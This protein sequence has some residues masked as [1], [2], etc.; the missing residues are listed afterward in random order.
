MKKSISEKVITLFLVS[1]LLSGCAGPTVAPTF[2]ELNVT[3]KFKKTVAIIDIDDRGSQIKGISPIVISELE[4][5]MFGYCNLVER[6]K[7]SAI[8][9][10]RQFTADQNAGTVT[11]LGR[12]LGADYVV[13][14][15]AAASTS[16]P[17]LRS[18]ESSHDGNFYGTIWEEVTA[19][20]EVSIKMIDVDSAMIVYSGTRK[21]QSTQEVARQTF[22]DRSQYNKTLNTKNLASQIRQVVTALVDM[23][24]DYS[25][26]VSRVLSSATENFSYDLRREFSHSGQ[27]LQIISDKE[28]IVNIGSAYGLKAGDDL[29]VLSDAKQI[30][31]PKTGL[32]IAPA[33][34]K[35]K[36]RVTSVTSGLSCIAKGSKKVISEL[37]VGDTVWT[38]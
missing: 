16:M 8:L 32:N 37:K 38:D 3:R 20:A 18:S 1:G 31:D 22:T 15:N 13:F 6:R 12:L 19:S 28:V 4:R 27:I 33:E 9:A 26:A 24:S 7:I 36:L 23:K 21:D 14:G 25:F 35:G 17:Q 11:E 30:I 2:E 10:E 5:V 29:V 34:K